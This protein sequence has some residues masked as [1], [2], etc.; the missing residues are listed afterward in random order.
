MICSPYLSAQ[1]ASLDAV[2]RGEKVYAAVEYLDSHSQEVLASLWDGL[3]AEITFQL[4]LYRRSKRP[5]AFLGDRLLLERRVYQTA[6]FDFYGNRYKIQR[7]GEHVGEYEGEA[8]FIDSFF[9]LPEIELGEID[10]TDAREHYLLARVRMMPVKIIAPLNIIT[11]FSSETAFTTPW[12]E[13]E[14]NP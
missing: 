14:L 1:Q 13:T 12:I 10:T 5:F 4:R 6:S 9:S 2:L 8:E 11:L 3:R 7:D